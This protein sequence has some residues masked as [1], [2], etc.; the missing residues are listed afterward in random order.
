MY[1]NKLQSATHGFGIQVHHVDTWNH[2]HQNAWNGSCAFAQM[3]L[4]GTNAAREHSPSCRRNARERSYALAL[5][6]HTSADEDLRGAMCIC[7]FCLYEIDGYVLQGYMMNRRCRA[8]QHVSC[9]E[10]NQNARERGMTLGWHWDV[11]YQLRRM[12]ICQYIGYCL[13]FPQHTA[14][15]C[16]VRHHSMLARVSSM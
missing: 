9:L 5:G 6:C 10:Y 16:V 3:N 11:Q 1:W 4:V 13:A 14:R 7:G 2:E 15:I 8:C 12:M